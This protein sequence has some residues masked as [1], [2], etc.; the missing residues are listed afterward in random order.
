LSVALQAREASHHS[1]AG[2]IYGVLALSAIFTA[3]LTAFYTFRAYFKTF[4]GDE[5]FPPEAGH[6]PHDAPPMMA[7]PLRILAVGAVGVGLVFGPLTHWFANI[8][9]HRW[10]RPQFAHLA[11]TAPHAMNVVLMLASTVVGLIG[12]GI[13]YWMYV[14]Q[15][16]LADAFAKRAGESYELSRNK[17]YFDE[18]YELIVVKPMSIIAHV[19]RIVDTYLI[20]GLVDLVGHLPGFLGYLVRPVQNGLVQFY[21]LLMALGLAGFLLSILL[22]GK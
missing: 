4:W 21:A 18:I 10:I 5:K 2:I 7:W 17:F 19:C 12:I 15:P 22:Q 16:S 13:A 20:D 9:E 14:K 8:L 6:H 3:G 1:A 11:P